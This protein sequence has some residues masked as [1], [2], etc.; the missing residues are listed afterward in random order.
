MLSFYKHRYFKRTCSPFSF[1]CSFYKTL[2]YFHEI[3]THSVLR[4]VAAHQLLLIGPLHL[5]S[6]ATLPCD[7]LIC[8]FLGYSDHRAVKSISQLEDKIWPMKDFT[9]CILLLILYWC[10]R[11]PPAHH[12]R[13]TTQ[14]QQRE[15]PK[16][17]GLDLWPP[18]SP[19]LN[20]VA[21]CI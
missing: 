5:H 9:R 19:D 14:L 10:K 3:I 16:F 13:Q 11:C 18:N 12:A 17:I 8:G 2:T 4:K 1:H 7:E 6:V 20:P 21:Y 15:T